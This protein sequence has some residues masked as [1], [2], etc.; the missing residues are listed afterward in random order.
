MELKSLNCLKF[1]LG[2]QGVEKT[3]P[4]SM[5]STGDSTSSV[6]DSRPAF[7]N[8]LQSSKQK[9]EL[10][11]TNF[12]NSMNHSI[13]NQKGGNSQCISDGRLCTS[14]IDVREVDSV[15]NNQTSKSCTILRFEFTGSEPLENVVE[16]ESKYCRSNPL[17]N[18]P[19]AKEKDEKT[20]EVFETNRVVN[21]SSPTLPD[22]SNWAAL[23]LE[24]NP[25][26]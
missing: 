16:F 9:N 8:A 23:F 15:L 4:K 26:Y 3:S 10:T 20:D 22:F 19:W 2:K 12:I 17:N 11:N 1:I 25:S 21:S 24:N 18:V 5:E 6:G 7:N 14:L 13:N